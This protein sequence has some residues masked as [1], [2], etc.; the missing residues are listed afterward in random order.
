MEGVS[1]DV[2]FRVEWVAK[3]EAERVIAEL[4]AGHNP[5]GAATMASGQ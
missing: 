4:R 1:G 3:G 2:G 5:P